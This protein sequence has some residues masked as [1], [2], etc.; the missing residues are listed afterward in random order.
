[1]LHL[2]ETHG[3]MER[4]L[5]SSS[6]SKPEGR[7]KRSR[8]HRMEDRTVQ[9]SDMGYSTREWSLKP[10]WNTLAGPVSPVLLNGG[11]R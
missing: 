11:D 4:M 10:L 1:M 2:L 3:D 9:R 5:K 7:I 8:G 6:D